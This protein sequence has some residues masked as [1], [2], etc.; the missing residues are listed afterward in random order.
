MHVATLKDVA[1]QAGVSAAT[2]SRVLTGNP[3]VSSG[4]RERVMR[5]IDELGYRPDQIARSL[6][7][8]RTNLL[9]LVVSTIENVFFTEV[10]RAAERAA[11]ARGYNLIVCNT[12]ESPER[13]DAYLS[14]LNEQLIAGVILAPAPGRETHLGRFAA[15]KL[16]IVLINRR[17]DHVP[18]TS[19]TSD[20][21]AAA[22][23]C[24]GRLIGEGRQRIAAIKGL[25]GISTTE[26]RLRG[27][28][29]ACADGGRPVDAEFETP[30]YATLDGGYQAAA[31]LMQRKEPPDALFA[32]NNVMTQGAVMALQDMGLHWPEQVDV[33]GFGAF[34]TARLYRPPLTLIAQPTHEMG[35]RAVAMLLAQVE[36][37]DG[38]PHADVVLRNRVIPRE[39]WSLGARR[40]ESSQ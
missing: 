21:E 33:A 27:Y 29:R 39:E 35:E 1:S 2:A 14:L 5:A 26:E 11:N 34:A 15:K 12:D 37:T 23:E 22:Y 25:P 30:G 20:D 8:R 38:A 36:G 6:R 13:E 7:R 32:F 16:P 3:R 24:V 9:G 40:G 28:R 18:F 17:P 4:A 10:A 19:I 31:K